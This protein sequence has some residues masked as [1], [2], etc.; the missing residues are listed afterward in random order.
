MG[1][2]SKKENGQNTSKMTKLINLSYDKSLNGMIGT[3]TAV[4][5]GDF[6][7][8]KY[9]SKLS[10][11]EALVNWQTS[12]SAAIGF[13]T[14]VGG[15]VTAAAAVP[16]GIATIIFN[17]IRMSSAVAHIAGFDLKAEETRSLVLLC[18]TG[19]QLEKTLEGTGVNYEILKQGSLKLGKKQIQKILSDQVVKKINAV[20]S[21]KLGSK[22]GGKV[23]S[24]IVPGI[25]GLIG[26]TF[27]GVATKCIG[28]QAKKIF[29]LTGSDDNIETKEE[30]IEIQ[31]KA[32]DSIAID[33]NKLYLYVNLIKSD[34]KLHRAEMEMME[35]L[36][37]GSTLSDEEQNKIYDCLM[38]DDF[39]PVNYKILKENSKLKSSIM[40]E[41]VDLCK[42][43]GD[44][45]EKEIKFI[46][47]VAKKLEVNESFLNSL[48]E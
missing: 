31:K 39:L 40:Y 47:S 7:N 16:A 28:N 20:V 18:L 44:I 1:L 17:Q 8:N 43:D 30:I 42:V 29:I 10:A 33:M 11:A 19:N 24:G 25:G 13:A 21:K 35:E 23:T 48:L 36:I 3:D 45:H 2:F 37:E 12:K 9:A 46:K 22:L 32:D 5:L 27:D 38:G 26:A 15:G 4:E 6:Y 14:G 34:E 41:L